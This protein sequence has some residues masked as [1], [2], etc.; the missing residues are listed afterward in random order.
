MQKCNGSVFLGLQIA[1]SQLLVCNSVV[2]ERDKQQDEIKRADLWKETNIEF[3]GIYPKK[4][5]NV[6][7]G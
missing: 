2:K 7:G 3:L 6:V 5:G 4:A 1:S